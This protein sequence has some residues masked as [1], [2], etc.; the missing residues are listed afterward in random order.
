MRNIKLSRNIFYALLALLMITEI[1]YSQD[2]QP[3]QD[4]ELV[5]DCYESREDYGY[6][7]RRDIEPALPNVICS[8]TTSRV[9]WWGDPYDGTIPLGDMPLEADYSHEEAVVTPREKQL[10]IFMPCTTCHNGKTVPVPKNKE[11]RLIQFHQDIVPNALQLM[12]G[13][14]SIWCLDCHS[15]TNRDKLISFRAEEISLNQPQKLCGKCHGEVYRDWR[16][17]IH[18]KRIGSWTKGGKKRWWVCTEC[19]NPHTVDAN[20]FLPIKPEP[21]PALPK[22]MKSADHEHKEYGHQ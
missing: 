5:K 19:H 8:Q 22:G 3:A 20:I 18:G 13:K 1:G 10:K 2:A 17:G 7:E 11:P 9:L 15:M 12:H 14:G 21:A 16:D 4:E 6:V